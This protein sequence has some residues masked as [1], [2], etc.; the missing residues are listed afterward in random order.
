MTNPGMKQ[1]QSANSLYLE[2]ADMFAH[3]MQRLARA[4]EADADRR[5]DLL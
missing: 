4:T 3:A 1:Q 2:A 5:R